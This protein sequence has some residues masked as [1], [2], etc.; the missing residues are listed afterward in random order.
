[1]S[2]CPITADGL[3]STPPHLPL[4]ANVYPCVSLCAKYRLIASQ[5]IGYGLAGLARDYL[6]YPTW[7]VYPFL[8]PQVQLFDAMH[9][10]KGVFLQRKLL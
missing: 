6:V 9:R 3:H 8:M 5:L 7:A 1:M 4:G 2:S 10:G